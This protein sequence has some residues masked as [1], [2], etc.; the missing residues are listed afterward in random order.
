MG[1]FFIYIGLGIAFIGLCILLGNKIGIPFG[2]MP[3]DIQVNS[4]KLG[5]YFPIVSCIIISILL[6][7]G[8]NLILW[9]LRK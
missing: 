5:F 3:G 1:K 6:T 7:L 9:I 2:K 8:I 4:G